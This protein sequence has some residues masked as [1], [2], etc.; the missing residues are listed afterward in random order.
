MYFRAK[1]STL[2]VHNSHFANLFFKTDCL[3]HLIY[4]NCRWLVGL[5]SFS[6]SSHHSFNIF[7]SVHKLCSGNLRFLLET[8]L[9]F[10]LIKIQTHHFFIHKALPLVVC[11]SHIAQLLLT[12]VHKFHCF[13]PLSSPMMEEVSLET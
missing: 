6:L 8:L 1:D 3:I 11:I 5:I 2:A 4:I 9:F 13:H 10:S 7:L 12:Q